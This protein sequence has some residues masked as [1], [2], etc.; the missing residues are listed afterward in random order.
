MLYIPVLAV[1]QQSLIN[2][3]K[4]YSHWPFTPTA[5]TG[6]ENEI[7]RPEGVHPIILNVSLK[8]TASQPPRHLPLG[9]SAQ[10]RHHPL[11]NSIVL[12]QLKHPG[13]DAP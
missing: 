2:R 9:P 1:A 5:C 13:E 3:C 7:L 12:K 11:N 4:L 6:E 10:W 8:D